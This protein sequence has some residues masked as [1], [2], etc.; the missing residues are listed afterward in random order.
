MD[1][2]QAHR[3]V[4]DPLYGD[5]GGAGEAEALREALAHLAHACSGLLN[6]LTL[7]QRRWSRF[8]GSWCFIQDCILPQ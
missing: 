3:D 1:R 5:S 2:F 6:Y 4:A 7:L 8:L